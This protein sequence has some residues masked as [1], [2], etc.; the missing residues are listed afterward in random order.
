MRAAL[1]A[2]MA[3]VP[4]PARGVQAPE[5]DP[6]ALQDAALQELR[7]ALEQSLGLREDWLRESEEQLVELV[8]VIAR[9]VIA[10]EVRS[11]PG[12][13]RALVREGLEALGEGIAWWCAWAKR[14][15]PLRIS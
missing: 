12:L 4:P 7:G 10:R 1:E 6:G 14:S 3:S 13:V 5:L 9:R 8:S 2:V 11:D 15:P